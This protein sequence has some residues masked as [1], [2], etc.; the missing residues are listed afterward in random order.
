MKII[1]IRNNKI[2]IDDDLYEW[3]KAQR[4]SFSKGHGHKYPK[5]PDGRRL[6]HIV[7]GKPG[8]GVVVDHINGNTLDNRRENLRVCTYSQNNTNRVQSATRRSSS[9]KGVVW[10]KSRNKYEA[11]IKIEG[12]L[13]YLGLFK[14]EKDAAMAYNKAA[15]KHFGEYAR[16]NAL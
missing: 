7:A 8:P 15:E 12:R 9:Y 4:W 3:A 16:L 2:L 10:N 13:T 6:H 14:S 5:L 1:E 11:H